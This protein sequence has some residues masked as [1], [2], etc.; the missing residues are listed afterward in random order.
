MP[1]DTNDINYNDFIRMMG[2]VELEDISQAQ[3]TLSKY[4]QNASNALN[5]SVSVPNHLI[6]QSTPSSNS[7]S[8]FEK[9]NAQRETIIDANKIHL[10]T[11]KGHQYDTIYYDEV[12]EFEMRSMRQTQYAEPEISFEQRIY[13]NRYEKEKLDIRIKKSAYK[14]KEDLKINKQDDYVNLKIMYSKNS[15]NGM[16]D[17]IIQ[18]YYLSGIFK[19]KYLTNIIDEENKN[20]CKEIILLGIQ[21]G[22]FKAY[23]KEIDIKLTKFQYRDDLN[24]VIELDNT[25]GTTEI[26]FETNNVE[27]LLRENVY[28]KYKRITT[29]NIKISTIVKEKTPI[30]KEKRHISN[31]ESLKRARET[32]E[33]L[34]NDMYSISKPSSTVELP[35]IRSGLD[36]ME[37]LISFISDNTDFMEDIVRIY[38]NNNE[39]ETLLYMYKTKIEFMSSIGMDISEEID[40]ATGLLK[41]LEYLIV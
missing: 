27:D 12:K 41:N 7:T 24:F 29:Y 35:T 34:N 14:L 3:S 17:N 10:N 20:L 32:N 19:T 25:F 31:G 16:L 13:F 2:D 11:L 38:L 39:F 9:L 23:D 33:S 4:M 21:N 37:K 8:I 18:K 6:M 36:K 30:V 26:I 5:E 28:P 1:T 22:F 40:K 15:Y